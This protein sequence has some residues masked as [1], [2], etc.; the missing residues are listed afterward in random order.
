MRNL[1]KILL[2]TIFAAV[3]IFAQDNFVSAD[4]GFAIDLPKTFSSSKDYDGEYNNMFT[5]GKIYYWQKGE[6]EPFYM[7]QYT[8]YSSSSFTGQPKLSLKN[9][10]AIL[11]AF[12]KTFVEKADA[13]KSMHKE[14]PFLFEGNTGKEWHFINSTSQSFVR[15]F[16]VKNT[17][18]SIAGVFSSSDDDE[19]IKKILN[20]F[21]LLTRQ[22]IIDIKVK[23]AEPKPLPQSPVSD[24]P[25]SDAHDNNLKGKV[26]SIIEEYQEAPNKKR[27]KWSEE[28]YN[29]QGNLTRQVGYGFGYPNY[30]T[31]WGYIDGNRVDDENQTNIGF[32]DDPKQGM[33]IIQDATAEYKAL[34]KDARYGTKYTY[35][36]NSDGQLAEKTTYFNS[37]VKSLIETFIYTGN[38]RETTERHEYPENHKYSAKSIQIYDKNGDLIE[39]TQYDYEGKFMSKTSYTYE[40]DTKGNWIVQKSFDNVKVKG[41]TVL[42]PSSITYRTITYYD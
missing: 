30:I 17:F 27:E 39:E 18:Y 34:P 12:G 2:L 29:E 16:F 26:K 20:S 5:E 31:V 14:S 15:S 1:I 32:D 10:A 38:R 22:E 6:N 24:K 36:Y 33:S 40:L 41:K 42:K 19:K 7:I 3:S 28:Y 13:A 9:K 21:R 4:G 35:K 8:K 37:G 11:S 25:F 23:L